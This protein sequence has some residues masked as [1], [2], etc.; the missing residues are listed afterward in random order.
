MEKK[1]NM[2][3]IRDY[4]AVAIADTAKPACPYHATISPASK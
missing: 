2:K 1:M 3:F 4:T